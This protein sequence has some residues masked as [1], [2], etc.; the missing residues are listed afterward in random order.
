MQVSKCL[1]CACIFEFIILLQVKFLKICL[2][3]EVDHIKDQIVWPSTKTSL[4]N[5]FLSTLSRLP[6][7]L[8][9]QNVAECSDTLVFQS[10]QG[11]HLRRLR[12][13]FFTISMTE[14]QCFK[15]HNL[16][17]NKANTIIVNHSIRIAS[18]NSWIRNLTS[19]HW[20][21]CYM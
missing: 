10:S 6:C 2:Y 14:V 18:S 13:Q 5:W 19:N 7:R 21:P 15:F 11:F 9:L 12:M 1:V 16:Q 4:L 20:K 3:F 17:N 8:S